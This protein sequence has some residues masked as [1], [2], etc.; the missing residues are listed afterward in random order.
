MIR[1][2]KQNLK[3]AYPGKSAVILVLCDF[4]KVNDQ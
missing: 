2:L 1:F 4:S 3:D